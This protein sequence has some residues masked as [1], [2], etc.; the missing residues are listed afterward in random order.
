LRNPC[1]ISQEAINHLLIDNLNQDLTNYTPLKLHQYEPPS[2]DFGHYAM[3]MIYPVT[4][5]SIGSYKCLMNNPI[6]AK[7]W[8]MTFGKDF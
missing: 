5:E 3:P 4:R 7:I 2:I 6:T 8:M 1:L